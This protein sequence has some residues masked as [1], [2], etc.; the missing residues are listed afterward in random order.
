MSVMRIPD[1]PAAE[2]DGDWPTV[3]EL[4]HALASRDQACDEQGVWPASLWSAVC[5]AGA[6]RWAMNVP[7]NPDPC[8]RQFLVQRYGKLAE[9]SLTAAF[10]L[11]QH[12]AAVRRLCSQGASERIVEWIRS[13]ASGATFATVGLSQLTTSKRHGNA[14]LQV[15]EIGSGTYSINGI[16]PWVTAAERADVLVAGAVFDDGRQL[17]FA[18]PTTNQGVEIKPTFALAA[19]QASCTAEVVCQNAIISAEDVMAG[20]S[21]DVMAI[22]GVAGTGG[23]ETSA[24][25]LGQTRAALSGI[26]RETAER[27]DDAESVQALCAS[28]R[29]LVE[30]L[31]ANLEGESGALPAVEIR[32][33]SNSLVLRATQAYLTLRKGSGFLRSDDAQRWARQALFFLVWSCPSPVAK[34][35]V[36]DFAGVCDR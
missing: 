28:W 21:D 4:A 2:T 15:V 34:A 1:W 25:A 11:T 18:L 26:L 3:T 12:D 19:V 27:G 24:L 31:L 30:A 10:I 29:G 16:I 5:D 35:A 14:A 23:L 9:G 33:K 13:V 8:P 17:L 32:Q 22:P 36:R 7:H 6:S 20:P